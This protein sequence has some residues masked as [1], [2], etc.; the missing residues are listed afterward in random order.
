[1]G[2]KHP[3]GEFSLIFP[4]VY[5]LCGP[6]VMAVQMRARECVP[7]IRSSGGAGNGSKYAW[8]LSTQT[9]NFLQN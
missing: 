4:S 3:S 1:M 2:A 7:F 9:A 5:P 8:A 6:V